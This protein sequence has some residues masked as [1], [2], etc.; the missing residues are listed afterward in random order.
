M[1]LVCCWRAPTLG[2]SLLLSPSKDS[3]PTCSEMGG[4]ACVRKDR[5]PVVNT[6]A[7]EGQSTNRQHTSQQQRDL[8][9]HATHPIRPSPW[10]DTRS[11]SSKAGCH[12]LEPPPPQRC[13]PA[14]HAAADPGRWPGSPASPHPSRTASGRGRGGSAQQMP[15]HP[16]AAGQTC[17]GW[18][19]GG[20]RDRDQRMAASNGLQNGG[21]SCVCVT[22]L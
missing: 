21:R 19:K 7:G 11:P 8:G 13:P 16:A 12:C 18:V 6:A 14:A 15:A 4:V 10:R 5:L 2:A 17:R 22:R 9:A 3:T 20:G 1:P